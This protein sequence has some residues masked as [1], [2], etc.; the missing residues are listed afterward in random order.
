MSDPLPVA[1]RLRHLAVD[2][3]RRALVECVAAE[4]SAVEAL[5][6]VDAAIA[7]ETEAA[8]DP[9]G[10]D[11]AVEDFA[12]WLRRI[13]VE[14]RAAASA[15]EIAEL[16]SNEAR[17]ALIACRTAARATDEVLRTRDADRKVAAD[18]KEQIGLEEA[19]R[20]G[21]GPN[22]GALE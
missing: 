8:G 18:R 4:A 14:R 12:N 3:A 7:A 5:R 16:R 15:L 6:L 11:H 17:T 20:Q 9:A 19:A 1:A 10:D 22:K 2:E 21:D 13:R